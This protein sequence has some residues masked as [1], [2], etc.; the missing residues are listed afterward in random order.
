VILTNLQVPIVLAPMAGGPSTPALAAAVCGAGGL[1]FIAGAYRTAD[2]LRADI[3]DLRQRTTAPFGVNLFVPGQPEADHDAIQA[4]VESLRPEADRLGVALGEPRFDD[5]GWAAKLEV[6]R[7]ELPA[8]VSFTFGCPAPRTVASLRNAGI[9]VWA[10]ATDLAEARAARDSGVDAIVLQGSE[11][12]A[13]R[14]SWVDRVDAEG[15]G[16]IALVRI[17]ATEIN[18]PLVA[19]GG[20]G[21]GAALAAV[22][23]AGAAA[24]QLGTAFLRATEAGTS[25]A[26]RSALA[27]DRPTALTRAFTGRLARGLVNRFMREHGDDAPVGYPYIHHVTAPL[28]AEAR[29]RGDADSVNLWAGQAHR[30]AKEAPAGEIVRSMADEAQDAIANVRSRLERGR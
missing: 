21:D 13:H 3:L 25:E 30:L 4:Y 7:A 16:V 24:A 6:V 23:S 28:R 1:G 18:L 15:L 17:A 9:E 19:A 12:G 22:L 14:A 2:E 27:S 8:V 11:A 10:T 26:H 29:R 20:I 5:D